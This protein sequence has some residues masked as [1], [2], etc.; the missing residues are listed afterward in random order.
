V[1][2]GAIAS[3][4]PAWL[5]LLWGVFLGIHGLNVWARKPFLEIKPDPA[6]GLAVRP[7]GPNRRVHRQSSQSKACVPFSS[8]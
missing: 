5:M 2:P 6:R 8:C 7:S 3:F 1:D 4:W